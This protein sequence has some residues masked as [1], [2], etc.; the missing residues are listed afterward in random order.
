M[1]ISTFCGIVSARSGVQF[2][3]KVD[4]SPPFDQVCELGGYHLAL[5]G[6]CPRALAE[7]CGVLLAGRIFNAIGLVARLD[8][9]P[10]SEPELLLRAYRKWGAGFPKYLEGEFAFV[11]W[12]R[13]ASRVL[14]GCGSGCQ[15]VPLFYSHQD[16]VFRF[17]RS[18]RQLV[19]EMG[20]TPRISE[21]YVARWLAATCVGSDC[22]FFE[23]VFRVIPGSVVAFE[24]GCLTQ[25]VYWQPEKTSL[26]YLHD[27]REYS[28]GLREALSNAVRDRLPDRSVG[29][30][31]SGGLDSSTVTSL[32]A[33]VL[34]SRNRRLFAFTAVPRHP[35]DNIAGRFCDEGPAAASVADRWPNVDHV[36]VRHG[37]H[38]V[39]SLMDLFGSE[40]LEPILNP[41]NYDWTYEICL[42]ARQ[43]Q[44]DIVLNGDSGNIS[45]SFAGQWALRSLAAEQRWMDLARLAKA[46]HRNGG[47]RW[48]GIA[49]EVLGLWIPLEI[50]KLLNAGRR[51]SY[52]L[53]QYSLIRREF[54]RD[55][56]LDSTSLEQDLEHLDSRSLRTRYLRRPDAGAT[57]DA[58]RKLTGVSRVDPLGDRRVIEFCLSVPIE[59]YCENGV[60]RSLIRNAMIGRL[61]EQVRTESRKGLQAADFSI[62]FA[63]ERAEAFAEMERM[64]KVDLAVRALDL[65]KLEQM[66]RWSDTQIAAHGGMAGYWP[67]VLRALSLGRF[68]R[69]FED[70]T[71]FAQPEKDADL[72]I[73]GS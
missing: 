3:T 17:A 48:L 52:G 64:K 20:V 25:D 70:G 46:M 24:R 13:T 41:G 66:M 26:L 50:R 58:F 63:R 14:L 29:S 59:N 49:N 35:V 73:A 12:D 27:P 33:E 39:F 72:A 71:L 67:K 45:A 42:Q 8:A 38:S 30:Q 43:R 51:G 15:S 55:H 11:L 4:G 16:G 18:L 32:A 21:D 61:P 65:E 28:D 9:R 62:H 69:R 44:V 5:Q 56:G 31:L 10:E 68:L 23:K 6:H 54:A 47:R 34:Q 40:Q 60:P 36:L 22:T 2:G 7:D 19:T 1:S 57:D 37:C 53:F